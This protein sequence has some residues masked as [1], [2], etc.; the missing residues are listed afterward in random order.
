[1]EQPIRT[2]PEQRFMLY[3][4]PFLFSITTTAGSDG[5][6]NKVT[7][8]LDSTALDLD[9]DGATE[10]APLSGRMIYITGIRILNGA[11]AVFGGIRLDGKLM[12]T[13]ST[14]GNDGMLIH[15]AGEDIHLDG[16]MKEITPGGGTLNN[17]LIATTIKRIWGT[18]ALVCRNTIDVWTYESSS[19][20]MTV[21]FK[22]FDL[23]RKF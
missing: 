19:N 16:L 6:S 7:V 11:D 14:T 1:M 12:L 22:G 10:T 13:G 5:Y 23:P 9:G 3:G 18:E 8:T 2:Y 4:T 15:A 21:W 17:S 20:T